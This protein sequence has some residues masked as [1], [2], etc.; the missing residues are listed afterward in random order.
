MSK[1]IKLVACNKIGITFVAFNV[2]K[3]N[4]ANLNENHTYLVETGILGSSGF[5]VGVGVE[6]FDRAGPGSR[7]PEKPR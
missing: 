1:A 3:Q 4:I 7:G 2:A 5:R 6:L